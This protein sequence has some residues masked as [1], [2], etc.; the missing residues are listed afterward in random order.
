MSSDTPFMQ[1]G[2][3]QAMQAASP[4]HVTE[5]QTFRAE[6][7]G[8]P[9]AQ[10]ADTW[11]QSCVHILIHDRS[12]GDLACCFRLAFFEGGK[13]AQSYSAQFYGLQSLYRFKGIQM[14]LGR[15]CVSSASPD[16]DV[17]RLAWAT[18]THFVDLHGV[19]L[20]FGCSS[21]PG[22]ETDRFSEALAYLF[23]H[24]VA[25]RAFAPERHASE[26]MLLERYRHTSVDKRLAL[27]Q[28]P[29]LLR[30]YLNMRGWVSDHVVID[31]DLNTFHV[32]TGVETAAIPALRQRTLRG[33]RRSAQAFAGAA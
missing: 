32:F 16:P 2:R 11:D 15:F 5:A 24:C 22:T 8:L 19:T 6:C 4:D 1:L 23:C 30:T 18:V 13:V 27:Q 26:V 31:R 17:L 20:L 25:P 12:T 9:V 21:F 14:E 3:F 7:F 29:P 10:D 33:L 28:M